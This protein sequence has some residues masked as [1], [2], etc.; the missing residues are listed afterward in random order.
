MCCEATQG[1]PRGW[2]RRRE[3]DLAQ[4]RLAGP[5][6]AQTLRQASMRP[7]LRN[8][9]PT[10]AHAGPRGPIRVRSQP[11]R[12]TAHAEAATVQHMG[13]DHRGR[14]VLVTQQLLHR[15]DVVTILQ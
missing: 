9:A 12:R 10:L 13:V 5:P 4:N 8:A 3:E 7:F 11:V 6:G 1:R 15:P 14:D 2:G